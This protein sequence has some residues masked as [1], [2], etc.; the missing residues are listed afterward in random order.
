MIK[1]SIVVP[2]FNMIDTIE[3]TLSSIWNQN[4]DNLELIVM[5]GDSTDGT[6]EF[7]NLHKDKID[8]FISKKDKGQYYAIQKGMRLATGEVV[9][10]LN[11]DDIYFPWTLDRVNLFFQSFE[12]INWIAGLPSFLDC[13]GNITHIYDNLSSR[14]QNFIRNGAFKNNVFGYLQ[15]ESMF[16]RKSL[17]DK[18]GG[19]DLDYTLAAD[20]E[21]WTRFAKK[22]AVVSVNIPL[23]GFRIDDNSRSKKYV[24]IYEEEVN[25]IV[26]SSGK[27]YSV[28][29]F[30]SKLNL[31]NKLIRL[32]TY[33]KQ[34]VIY[35]SITKR[36]W[37][38]KS[39]IL[40]IST[41]SF[42]NLKLETL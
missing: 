1:I 19:L 4:Y 15:Q 20:F 14:P 38:C 18:V 41:V 7:L 29:Q 31:I 12:K 9:S 8:V 22:S 25:E 39:F 17:W 40:P 16:F 36:K 26:K 34:K 33:R 3:Q 6:K 23:S 2:V 28:I 42:S 24:R 32:L 10:W 27:S 35:Y 5:D 21:L 13:T 11:A 30:L 37:I